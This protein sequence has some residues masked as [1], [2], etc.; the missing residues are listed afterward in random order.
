MPNTRG[1]NS[2]IDNL[3]ASFDPA[4]F[5]KTRSYGQAP[6]NTIITVSYLVGGGILANTPKGEIN[7][8]TN[9]SFDEIQFHL[10]EMN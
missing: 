9:V 3:G 7:R 8:I 6:A 10:V 2:S 4:N 5:L 1:L